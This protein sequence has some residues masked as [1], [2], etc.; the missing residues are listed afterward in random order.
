MLAT[1]A[2]ATLSGTGLVGPTIFTLLVIPWGDQ[3]WK[4]LFK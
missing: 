4:K 3:L 2:G 1:L